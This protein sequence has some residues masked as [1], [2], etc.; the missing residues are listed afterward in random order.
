M[1]K[2][3]E[4]RIKSL[5][6]A[7]EVL[8]CFID[9]QPL[10]ATEISEK[11]GIYKSNAFDILST[12]AAMDYLSKNEETGKYYLGLGALRLGRAAGERYGF[13]KIAVTHMQEIADKEQE[14][15]Y[16]SVPIGNQIYYLDKAIPSSMANFQTYSMQYVVDM[17]HCTSCGKVMLA[18]MPKSFIDE[19]TSQP[20][21][22]NTKYTI[23]DPNKLKEELATIRK[24]GYATD[25]MEHE[26]GIN[27]VAVPILDRSG[28]VIAAISISGPSQRLPMDRITSLAGE[29]HKH[30]INI[31]KE[32]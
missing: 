30:V 12:L 17:M 5:K 14:I 11:L 25:I 21:K 3:C 27:C 18:N 32:L 20:L 9:K 7:L 6:K 24:R 13:K 22:A 19:Y 4:V 10:G 2:E 16:L 23:T 31:E 29:I 28:R 26:I 8:N 1:G 15:V